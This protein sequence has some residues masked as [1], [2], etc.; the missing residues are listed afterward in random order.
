MST[1][2][3]R[4]RGAIALG[5][6]GVALAGSV[7]FAAPASAHTPTWSV[8]CDSVSVDLKWYAAQGG[9][10]VTVT[11][12]GEELLNQQFG[13]DFSKEL[14]LPEHT[15]PLEVRLVVDAIDDNGDK[16]DW[17]VDQT[18][19]SPVCE[20]QE[21][22]PEPSTPTEEPTPTP[23][24]STSEPAEPT[25]STSEPAV[26]PTEEETTPPTDLAETGSSDSTPLIAGIAAAVVAAGAGLLVVTRK[27]RA[28]KA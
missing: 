24:P 20:G 23:E 8:D 21:P 12:G 17:D 16:H 1:N 26:E 5:A 13:T 28:T 22:S 27:R 15:E 11:A 9:N 4:R 6:A 7:L 19:T 10:T 3:H 18:K 25:P 14:P 2:Q